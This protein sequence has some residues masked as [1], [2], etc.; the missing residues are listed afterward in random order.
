MSTLTALAEKY[1]LITARLAELSI[2]LESERRN[3]IDACCTRA[4]S[5]IWRKTHNEITDLQKEEIEVCLAI[6]VLYKRA[7]TRWNHLP[8]GLV[9]TTVQSTP[10]VTAMAAQEEL[11]FLF[12]PSPC[13][14]PSPS[15]SPGPG[16]GPS[17]GPSPALTTL[18]ERHALITEK[19]AELSIILASV[20]R[21]LIDGSST[22]AV[23][24]IWLN[25]H[26]EITDLQ[27]DEIKVRLAINKLCKTATTR[28]SPEPI[29]LVKTTV[30]STHPAR[31]FTPAAVAKP[32]KTRVS[33]TKCQ[34]L[35]Q[36]EP[37]LVTAMAVQA[38]LNGLGPVDD[39]SNYKLAV[40]R[41]MSSGV[42]NDFSNT[43]MGFL[44]DPGLNFDL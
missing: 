32:V 2:I 6:N 16:P 42:E 12:D 13:L 14:S 28:L 21:E 8:K 43:D 39:F 40:F 7:S 33:G 38:D 17:P 37:P 19:L 1:A 15:P 23:F 27:E 44:L 25:T 30:Q 11:M 9:K 5:Q 34:M 31:L 26:Y 3:L 36:C 20:R 22:R 18:L 10:L 24:Q 35:G 4:V 41:K 29:G